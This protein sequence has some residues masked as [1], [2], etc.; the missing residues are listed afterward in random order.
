MSRILRR[1][2][3]FGLVYSRHPEITL[4]ATISLC[5]VLFSIGV[6]NAGGDLFAI[7]LGGAAIIGFAYVFV[8]IR[9]LVSHDL[10]L[11]QYGLVV[12]GTVVGALEREGKGMYHVTYLFDHHKPENSEN[13]TAGYEHG[14]GHEEER[15]EGRGHDVSVREYAVAFWAPPRYVFLPGDRVYLVV[16]P[17]NPDDFLE[18]TGQYDDLL[19]GRDTFSAP[20]GEREQYSGGYPASSRDGAKTLVDEMSEIYAT[21]RRREQEW[22]RGSE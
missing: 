16:D 13:K 5:L 21:R 4:I 22:E 2:V 19:D 1:A 12:E 8:R 15:G 9:G 20:R 3:P 11:L 18:I 7:A 14:E 6:H 10:S 17:D